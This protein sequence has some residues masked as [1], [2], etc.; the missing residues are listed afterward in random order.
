[1]QSAF[2]ETQKQ[3]TMFN[4]IFI[5]L[6]TRMTFSRLNNK[7]SDF[8][9]DQPALQFLAMVA[10]R[11]KTSFVANKSFAFF[12]GPKICTLK[13]SKGAGWGRCALTL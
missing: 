4:N 3:K 10:W 6:R 5:E 1:M 11:S 7:F 2:A 12:F 9:Q 8:P 13:P